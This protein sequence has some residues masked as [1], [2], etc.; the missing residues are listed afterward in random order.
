MLRRGVEAAFIRDL[1]AN[2]R[3][4]GADVMSTTAERDGSDG[5]AGDAE[6]G[7]RRIDLTIELRGSYRSLLGLISDLS[8][9]NQVVDV[10]SISLRRADTSLI[11]RVPIS[12]FEASE[13]R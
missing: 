1:D 4:H 11:A 9:G 7:M 6:T 8:A 10:R 3:R 2:V 13:A 12:V 5:S